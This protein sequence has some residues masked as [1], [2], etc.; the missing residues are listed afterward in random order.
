MPEDAHDRLPPTLARNID[1]RIHRA[2]HFYVHHQLL[3]EL[4]RTT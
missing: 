2:Y 3:E 4:F 1:S